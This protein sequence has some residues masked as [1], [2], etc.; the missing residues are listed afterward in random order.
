[1]V[2]IEALQQQFV[3]LSRF[4]ARLLTTPGIHCT[5]R[6]PIHQLLLQM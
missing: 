2:R 4:R 6:R 3:A 1:M 5:S